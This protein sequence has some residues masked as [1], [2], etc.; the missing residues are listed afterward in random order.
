MAFSDTV[1]QQREK[2]AK[3][4][5]QFVMASMAGSA[6]LHGGGLFLNVSHLW[7]PQEP[8]SE[9]ITIV[10]TDDESE[11]AI[12]P[13]P[14][15]SEPTTVPEFS[16]PAVEPFNEPTVFDTSSPTTPEPTAEEIVEEP[17]EEPRAEEEPVS[18]EDVVPAS[19]GLDNLL[20]EL[21][22]SRQRA[23]PSAAAMSDQP[24]TAGNSIPEN[25][26]SVS[27]GLAASPTR[28]G[29]GIAPQEST[30]PAQQER[31]SREITCRGC[32]FDY[33]E[34]A[35]GAEGT[36]QV[37]VETDA[38]GRVVAVMLS[39]SSGNAA[40]D[41]AALEQARRRVRLSNARAGESYPIDVDFVQPDSDAAQRARE[42]SD[43]RSITVLDPEPV[44]ET[45]S[46]TPA[47]NSSPVPEPTL[48]VEQLPTLEP[49]TEPESSTISEP[50]ISP[51]LESPLSNPADAEQP[52]SADA[53]ASNEPEPVDES[54]P[55]PD[56]PS[57]PAEA[58]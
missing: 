2:Q 1:A 14:P 11:M 16:S 30:T 50:S 41:R 17:L 47:A 51:V 5:K 55:P 56:P 10:V 33:P 27:N 37:V 45:P 46:S 35:N 40:L 39:R 57:A 25:T 29:F 3:I 20:A 54:S 21:R 23:N 38:Q 49:S 24:G 22:Q 43:R 26:G 44:V 58:E 7:T 4:L 6:V 9:D 52:D 53:S 32:D 48:S 36:A 28:P 18:A 34:S 12:A 13:D 31:R 42:R 15:S 8:V 19:R